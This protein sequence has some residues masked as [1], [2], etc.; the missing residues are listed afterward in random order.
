MTIACERTARRRTVSKT[1]DILIC[2][3]RGTCAGRIVRW[4]CLCKFNTGTVAG[5]SETRKHSTCRS[6]GIVRECNASDSNITFILT[7]GK[8]RFVE[9]S[10]DMM[11]EMIKNTDCSSF[12]HIRRQ[13]DGAACDTNVAL[14]VICFT[15]WIIAS[16]AID[17]TT[18]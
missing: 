18:C 3:S 4:L 7:S 5:P 13:D 9:L 8:I 10:F 1:A 2:R 14:I 17:T 16:G 6:R 15:I 12:I 11:D